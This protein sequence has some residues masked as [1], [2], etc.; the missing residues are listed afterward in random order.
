MWTRPKILTAR[1]RLSTTFPHVDLHKL[2]LTLWQQ[3][4][5]WL[6]LGLF[7]CWPLCTWLPSP[8]WSLG[9]SSWVQDWVQEEHP[10]CST[11][12]SQGQRLAPYR[13]F[14]C[15]EVS[16]TCLYQDFVGR[17]LSDIVRKTVE[18]L[19]SLIIW[20]IV[21]LFPRGQDLKLQRSRFSPYSHGCNS[22]AA[23][24]EVRSEHK[25][26]WDCAQRTESKQW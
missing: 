12:K 14:T 6:L 9:A 11:P 17:G 5:H 26:L 18:I 10:F 15:L 7:T 4:K 16:D 20:P 8:C 24:E 21:A 3:L 1:F 25:W 2:F 19:G 23:E 22:A 13:H